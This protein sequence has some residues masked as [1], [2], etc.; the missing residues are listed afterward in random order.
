SNLVSWARD[1]YKRQDLKGE[2]FMVTF[3]TTWSPESVDQ[4]K[5]LDDYIN[6][7][8]LDQKNSKIRM[9]LV[10]NQENQKVVSNFVKRGGY[11]VEVLLDESGEAGNNYGIKTLPTTFFVGSDGSIKEIF[12]G[13]MNRSMLVDKIEN[14]LK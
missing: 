3:W 8:S 5:I 6:D 4:I 10:N 2:P 9:L 1:V 13:T 12:V 11:D 7:S 14:L